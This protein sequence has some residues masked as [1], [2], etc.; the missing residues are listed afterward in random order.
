MKA[1]FKF[2]FGY[3]KVP[4]SQ[5]EIGKD[6]T[7][8]TGEGSLTKTSRGLGKV[9]EPFSG[10][11]IGT[12]HQVSMTTEVLIKSERNIFSAIFSMLMTKLFNR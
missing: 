5:V 6:Y 12:I 9:K 10:Q 1:V 7:Y 3:I 11:Q 4:F 8:I 2:N